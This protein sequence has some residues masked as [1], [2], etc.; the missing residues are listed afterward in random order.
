MNIQRVI[1]GDQ[2]IGLLLEHPELMQRPIVIRSGRALIARPSDKLN[3][4]F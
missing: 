1:L 3:A 4:L 2:V